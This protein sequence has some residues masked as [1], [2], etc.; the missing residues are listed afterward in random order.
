MDVSD[1]LGEDFC[2]YTPAEI[3]AANDELTQRKEKYID[4]LYELET[5][6]KH[7]S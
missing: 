2:K 6:G 5:K 3:K 4:F 7:K 1:K